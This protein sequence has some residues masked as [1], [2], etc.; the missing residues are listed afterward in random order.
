MV[1]LMI[2][3]PS[4]AP[5]SLCKNCNNLPLHV[6]FIPSEFSNMVQMCILV[7]NLWHVCGIMISCVKHD[8]MASTILCIDIKSTSTW[9]TT[10]VTT[11]GRFYDLSPLLIEVMDVIS[12]AWE[13]HAHDHSHMHR[14]IVK[15]WHT[16]TLDHHQF[17]TLA[18]HQVAPSLLASYDNL[19][20]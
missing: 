18:P 1:D 6:S 7:H 10:G 4:P 16:N 19:N 15:C 2:Y 3:P 13:A 9:M 5:F 20:I 14:M 11:E 12:C 17:F 8:S